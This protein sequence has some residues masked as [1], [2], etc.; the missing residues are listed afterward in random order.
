MKPVI[1]LCL[2]MIACVLSAPAPLGT[3]SVAVPVV[4]LTGANAALL[5]TA[6]LAKKAVLV[7][8]L[9]GAAAARGSKH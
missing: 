5:G 2:A 7:G 6:L 3:L 9:V 4:T 1:F 8:G